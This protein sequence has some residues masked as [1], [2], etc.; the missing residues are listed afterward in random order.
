MS[1]VRISGGSPKVNDKF[2]QKL[3]VLSYIDLLRVVFL[4]SDIR[5]VPSVIGFA[6][7]CGEYNITETAGFNI[8]FATRKYHS[9]EVGISQ[10]GQNDVRVQIYKAN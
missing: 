5:L 3:V 10:K 4:R 9:G 2:R 7:F 6:C 8:N 1:G